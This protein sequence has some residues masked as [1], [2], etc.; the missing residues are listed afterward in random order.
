MDD[1]GPAASW[2]TTHV[3]KVF[4]QAAKS[5]QRLFRGG[6]QLS[7]VFVAEGEIGCAQGSNGCLCRRQRRAEVV[8]YRIQQCGAQP[9]DLGEGAGRG[10]RLLETLLAKGDGC[11]SGESFQDPAVLGSQCVA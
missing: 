6:E 5:I 10:G 9:V 8:A 3:E 11:L 4:Y 1:E 2:E 7:P